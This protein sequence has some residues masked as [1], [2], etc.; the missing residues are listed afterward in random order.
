MC[1][2][3]NLFLSGVHNNII[4]PPSWIVK[5]PRK[6]SFK[7][8]LRKVPKKKGSNKRRVSNKVNDLIITKQSNF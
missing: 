8:S 6:G 1:T 4:V 7:S 2:L 3:I 5:L